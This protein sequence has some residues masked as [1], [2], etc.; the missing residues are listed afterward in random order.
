MASPALL[1]RRDGQRQRSAQ[2]G[3]RRRRPAKSSRRARRYRP[4]ALK[5]RAL[6]V[7]L[8]LML[9]MV[10]LLGRLAQLQLLQGPALAGMAHQQQ[11]F[12]GLNPPAERRPIVDRQGNV[13]AIDQARFTLY[14]HPLL[15][16]QSEQVIA[17][18]LGPMLN[19]PPASLVETFGQQQTGIT[20]AKDLSEE[21]AR[22]IHNLRQ[23]GLELIPYL[24][25]FYPQQ[26]LFSEVVGYVDLEGNAQAGLEYTNREELLTPLGQ[27]AEANSSQRFVL[28]PT[29]QALS[30]DDLQLQLTLDSRLQR[31]AQI[32]LRQQIQK[33]GAERGT[34]LV[35][36]AKDGSLLSMVTE[37]SFDP[38]TYFDADLEWIKNWAVSDLY[39]PG[40]TFK[41]INVAIALEEGVAA[42]ATVYDQGHIKIGKWEI[43][44]ADYASAGGRGTLTLAQ[45][46][47][48]S[49]NVG[50]VHLMAQLEP[51]RYFN[52]LVKL[53]LG[54]PTGIDLPAEATA[55][56]KNQ[57]Q[58]MRSRIE[59]ATTA[60]GQG[61]AM[62]PLQML[63]LQASLANG[64]RLVTPHVVKG[65]IDSQGEAQWQPEMSDAVQVF[66]PQTTTE[67]LKMM[68]A[69]VQDG[70][71]EPAQ[72]SG[73]R[74]GGKTGTAQK[75]LNGYYT[76]ERI[77]SF[78]G[79]LPVETPRY[80]ILAVVD[81]PKGDDAYGSTV[82]A[83]IVKTMIESLVSI[84]GI[85]PTPS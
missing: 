12:Y 15:F 78:V 72:V 66:S 44:N 24:R 19:Q 52:W 76:R 17:D 38:N 39:E 77:T 16:K 2:A 35:M 18:V 54:Q 48:H 33:Y 27:R 64:G 62:T 73:Y 6:F 36:D 47:Q 83:P 30:S 31:V 14:A 7:W 53:G 45:V 43:K 10:G 32:S 60:F 11:Q 84:E 34:V 57:A 1:T 56:L 59:P 51:E 70:T 81:S 28:D 74:I 3:H 61:F 41:P 69:V 79:I 9:A 55:Q 82:A 25:R 23:D 21:V 49:S 26:D 50:M 22:K 65:L 4:P 63:Q 71:G 68:E 42:D 67:V 20:V 85:P 75:A 37:P 5:L 80:V 40:S 8:V 13:L 58:F 29:D 46:L